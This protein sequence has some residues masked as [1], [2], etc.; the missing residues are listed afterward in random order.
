MRVETTYE[1]SNISVYDKLRQKMSIW[2]VHI[3]KNPELMEILELLFT[4]EEAEL[5]ASDAFSAPFQDYRTAE[6]IAG[7]TGKTQED[8]EKI[9]EGLEQKKLIFKCIDDKGETRYSL[10]AL[11]YGSIAYL[12]LVQEPEI[13]EKILP[14]FQKICTGE[15]AM[16]SG[17]T[18]YPWG[19]VV[20]VGKSM[21]VVNEIL[22][23]EEVEKLMK[24]ARSI[25]VVLCFCRSQN[26]CSHPV[27]TCMGF[28]EGADYMVKGGFGRYLNHDEALHL[29]EEVEEA[30]LVHTAVRTKRG[31]TFMCNCC[32][33]ACPILRRLTDME[34]PREFTFSG[35]IPQIDENGC[36]L[37]GTRPELC[38][39]CVDIC[40]FDALFF[41]PDSDNPEKIG[42]KENR[43]VGCGLC[44][45]H[46]PHNA[47]TMV[48]AE[49]YAPE[50]QPKKQTIKL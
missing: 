36:T 42:F 5:L 4:P 2:I 50:F 47:I 10:L 24:N 8:V 23:F 7:C 19:R 45:H 22:P 11:E 39:A 38:R 48:T 29:L 18:K 33:C 40:P 28:N 12:T 13:R 32:T 35:L 41:Y 37:C 15:I 14:L 21:V 6:E 26:P 34:N 46:C 9:I 44:A 17:V 20:P 31:I 30:G 25:A 43:C 3:E 16:G 49:G 1:L 27:E